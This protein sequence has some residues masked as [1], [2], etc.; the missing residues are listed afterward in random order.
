M[1]TEEKYI[2][3]YPGNWLFNSSVVGFI[4]SLEAIEKKTLSES[5]QKNGTVCI[6]RE[7][8]K[9]LEIEKRYFS[10][11]LCNCLIVGNVSKTAKEKYINYINP[12]NKGDREGF[13]DFVKEISNIVR[14]GRIC[15]LSNQ[16]WTFRHESI[17][18]LNRIWK[19]SGAKENG[20][21]KFL[22]STAQ[23][24][25][26]VDQKLGGSDSF[27]N[28]AWANS[29]NSYLNPLSSF[30][31]IH[32][33]LAFT[34]LADGTKIFINAPSFKLMY[35][36]NQ[37]VS[38]LSAKENASYRSL[39]AMSIVEFSVRTKILL[40]SWVSMDI[41]IVAQKGDKFD[42]VSLPYRVIRLISNKRIA[43]IISDIGDFGI[44]EKVITQKWDC[45]VETGYRLLKISLNGIGKEDQGF[46]SS[47]Y[48]QN[49]GRDEYNI[50]ILANK[51]LK[52]YSLLDEQTKKL[53]YEWNN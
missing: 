6:D 28:G 12:S 7:I 48:F 11:K 5:L 20:F 41:E 25:N 17:D 19:K 46:L 1:E 53:D 16:N 3:L 24:T 18:N 4:I 34:K 14:G 49:G 40:N 15:S 8:F 9:E 2:E 42:F 22:N 38:N 37:L 29:H 10:E 30:L 47:F 43:G 26:R 51:I 36:L 44:L 45:L 39:L 33:H 21:E 32:H 31:I 50:K 35:L 13:P 23:I 52:L 27:P